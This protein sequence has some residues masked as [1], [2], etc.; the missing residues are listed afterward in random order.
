MP[1]GLRQFAFSTATCNNFA[2][3]L[4]TYTRCY[5]F[6]N[7]KRENRSSESYNTKLVPRESKRHR[8]ERNEKK[9]LLAVTSVQFETAKN[10]G[11]VKVCIIRQVLIVTI[12]TFSLSKLVLLYIRC[13]LYLIA[14]NSNSEWN[15]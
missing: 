4:C 14:P 5:S 9:K 10:S 6:C 7:K 2:L 3:E 13:A 15:V 1:S 12:I 11:A 8:N